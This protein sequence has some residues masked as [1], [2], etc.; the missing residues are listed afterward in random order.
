MQV[1]IRGNAMEAK[2]AKSDR[3]DFRLASATARLCDLRAVASSP[4]APFLR[5]QMRRLIPVSEES[6]RVR[7]NRRETH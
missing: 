4:R 5:H 2:M 1:S 7:D 6:Q 3:L